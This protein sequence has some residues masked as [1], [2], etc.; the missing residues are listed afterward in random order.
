MHRNAGVLLIREGMSSDDSRAAERR[1]AE[2]GFVVLAPELAPEAA[3]SDR[4][5]LQELERALEAL[6]R[7]PGVERERLGAVGLGRGG[8]LAFLLGCTRRLAAVVDVDGPVLYPELSAA[9][10][11]QP[12]ELTLNFEGAFLGVF[13]GPRGPVGTDEVALL[14]QRLSSAARSFDIV[15]HV[16][17]EETWPRVLAFLRA[18]L[19]DE[20]A[21][22]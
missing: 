11:I 3:S 18:H 22:P 13:S 5:G 2:A 21:D 8:T 16:P 1:L 17:G 9:R 10:P 12:L 6:A 14:R 7:S 19:L 4:R 15:L 20:P